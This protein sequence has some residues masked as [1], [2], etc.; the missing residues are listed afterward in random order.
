MHL[1]YTGA[2]FYISGVGQVPNN[3]ILE[4]DSNGR[5]PSLYCLSGSNISIAGEWF[6]P[7]GRNLVTIPNDPFN[8]IFGS[9]D[10]PG[11]LLIE[12]PLSNPPITSND[13]GVYTCIM[14][15]E[16][17]V[18]DQYLYIGIYRRASKYIST[19]MSCSSYP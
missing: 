13:E 19:I 6:S 12:T 15:D 5:I 10:D 9:G 2:G 16:Y 4:T 18:E 11:A 1:K 17:N 14:P 8:V 7:D 3:T